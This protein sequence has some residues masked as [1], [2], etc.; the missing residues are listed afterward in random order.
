MIFLKIVGIS[1]INMSV[2]WEKPSD[3]AKHNLL[4]VIGSLLQVIDATINDSNISTN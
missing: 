4:T 3:I 1:A 2:K